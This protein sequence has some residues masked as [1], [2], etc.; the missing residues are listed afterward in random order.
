MK[1]DFRRDARAALTRAKAEL[2]SAQDE[3]IR[4]AALELRMCIESLAY[5]RALDYEDDLSPSEYETWQPKKLVELLIEIEPTADK[6]GELR[7]KLETAP[8]E[9]EAPW[10][11]LGEERVFGLRL[12]A[13]HY[14]WL[15]SLLHQPTLKNLLKDSFSLSKY[16]DRCAVLVEELD[17]VLSS[18]IY[19]VHFRTHV[20][21][22][23]ECGKKI[24]KRVKVDGADTIATC[25]CKAQYLLRDEPG[26]GGHR[27]E[28][29]GTEV[30]CKTH[31]CDSV[32]FVGKEYVKPGTF[33]RCK[34]CKTIHR[35]MLSVSVENEP[36]K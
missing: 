33:W 12:I 11:N 3:R 22:P 5:E 13:D 31:G 24:R 6:G 30:P 34:G 2:A 21:L 18:P 14:H 28:R 9:P 17:A 32:A 19:N 26:T 8:G 25:E 20:T 4:Y 23:C 27:Y 10:Q 36:D 35:I 1:Y 16:R 7:I 15:G 29:L